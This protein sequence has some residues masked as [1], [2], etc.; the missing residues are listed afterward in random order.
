MFIMRMKRIMTGTLI[1]TM[2]IVLMINNW[3]EGDS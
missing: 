3:I 2:I 1:T